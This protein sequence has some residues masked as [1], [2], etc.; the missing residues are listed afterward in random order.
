MDNSK[1]IFLM[2]SAGVI[3]GFVNGLF[4]GGGGMVVVPILIYLLGYEVK[5]AH[6]TA[7]L[8]ILPISFIS[9]IIYAYSGVFDTDVGLPAAIGVVL[10]GIAGAKLLTR[11]KADIV[12][13]IF[14]FVMLAAGIKMII[15]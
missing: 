13:K 6:A 8:I 5:T 7:I 1:R 3:T 11:L 2:V 15:G 10:G 12:T 14:S 9:A 4:G